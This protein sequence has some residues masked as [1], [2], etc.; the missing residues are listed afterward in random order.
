MR[1][2]LSVIL[3]LFTAFQSANAGGIPG[4]LAGILSTLNQEIQGK[5]IRVL[6]GDTIEVLQDKKP[7]R[8]RLANIDAPEK[9][10]A[11]G[12]WSANQLKALLAAQ[13]VTVTYTQTDR[14]GRIIGHV[15]TTNGTDVSRFMVQSG[16]AWVYERYNVDESLPALQREAQEQKRGLWVDANPV[17][18][19]EWRHEY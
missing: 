4:A 7:V 14:Y 5:V 8:I 2:F 16:A 15:F 13:P 6:D 3:F 10:Q 1:I 17:P 18:P 11:F 19:W 9:K 12:R